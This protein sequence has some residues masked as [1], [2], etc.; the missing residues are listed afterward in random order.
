MGSKSKKRLHSVPQP[1]PAEGGGNGHSH[2]V[3]YA[4]GAI[5]PV[6]ETVLGAVSPTLEAI[7]DLQR[8]IGALQEDYEGR[9]GMLMRALMEKRQAYGE[10]VKQAGIEM[11]L[12]L[13]PDSKESWMF[14]PK[15][16]VFARQA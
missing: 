4:V 5:V 14:D 8:Q 9:Y 12:N 16:K 1:P 3:S 15:Q 7:N 11:G 13:G 10:Q 2:P 6:P